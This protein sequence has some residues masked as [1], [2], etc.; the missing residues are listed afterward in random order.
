MNKIVPERKFEGIQALIFDFD[1][2]L[3]DASKAI[4]HSFNAAL[5]FHGH[6]GLEDVVIKRL[7]GRPLR[8]MFIA[9]RPD[10]TSTQIDQLI[11]HYREVFLPVAVE[12]STPIAGLDKMCNYFR[13]KVKMAIAT[14]R[15]SDGAHR[16]LDA[17]KLREA[18][19]S[20]VG[21]QDVRK[22][23]PDPE[24]VLLAL[25]RLNVPAHAAIMIG[26]T[27]A[28]MQAGKGAGSDVIGIVSDI[29]SAE[30]LVAAGADAVIG[31]LDELINIV[32][33]KS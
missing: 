13:S 27:P 6:E 10:Q 18:F 2:T 32:R 24:A 9:V 26:D 31:S 15:V 19:D 7:I 8:D 20:I 30:E 28:D 29:Y 23:K 5:T 16:I 21:L 17:L 33:V 3:V 4:C 11:D 22:P 1:G 14:S 12:L 25:A